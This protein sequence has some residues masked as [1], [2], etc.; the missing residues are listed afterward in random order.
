MTF[1]ELTTAAAGAGIIAARLGKSLC[2]FA[3]IFSQDLHDLFGRVAPA[4]QARYDLHR[5]VNVMKERLIALAQV[6]QPGFCIRR[7]EKS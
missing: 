7:G 5:T 1:L 6:V 3:T 2:R 4:Q